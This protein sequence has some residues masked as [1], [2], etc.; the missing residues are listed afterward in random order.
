MITMLGQES[1][2]IRRAGF[3]GVLGESGM[4]EKRQP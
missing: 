4:P 1:A 2:V 3:G